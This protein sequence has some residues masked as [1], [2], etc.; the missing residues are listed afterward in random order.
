M[1]CPPGVN[2]AY[3]GHERLVPLVREVPWTHNLIIMARVKG[4]DAR[5]SYLREC[6]AGRWGKRGLNRQID[7]RLYER[8][9]RSA[10]RNTAL[11]GG[12]SISGSQTSTWRPSTGT[13]GSRAKT[14]PSA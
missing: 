12:P 9:T 13:C 4:D 7:F 11:V 1:K 10:L 6:A 2:R 5:E 3:D 14:R 8:P